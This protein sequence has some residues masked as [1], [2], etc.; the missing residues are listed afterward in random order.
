M[1][2]VTSQ[3]TTIIYTGSIIIMADPQVPCPKSCGVLRIKK[4]KLQQHLKG[5]CPNYTAAC[6]HCKESMVRRNI[7][8]HIEKTCLKHVMDCPNNCGAKMERL[9]LKKHMTETCPESTLSCPEGCGTSVSR[10]G[11]QQHLREDCPNYI[12]GCPQHCGAVGL[13]RKD[14]PQ[15]LTECCH[16]TVRCDACDSYILETWF[17]RHVNEE[18]PSVHVTCPNNC[19]VSPLQKDLQTH[20]EKSCLN[21]AVS[22]PNGCSAVLKR[23]NLKRHIQK[24]CCGAKRPSPNPKPS[25]SHGPPL[26][27]P[28]SPA[29]SPASP[30]VSAPS[31]A[32]SP[33]PGPA[34]TQT[35][36]STSNLV[37]SS[38]FTTC[39]T[40][41]DDILETLL[42]CHMNDDCPSVSVA[43][44][45]NCGVSPLR[46]HLQKHLEET[47]LNSTTPCP[48]GCSAKVKRRN[49]K[50]HLSKKCRRHTPNPSPSPSPTRSTDPNEHL[51]SNLTNT[52]SCDTCSG[53]MLET[54][55][56]YHM[57]VEC[58]N[59][60]VA[61]PKNCGVSLLRKDLEAHFE[62]SCLNSTVPC[63][64]GCRAMVKR[65]NLDKHLRKKCCAPS[66]T[67]IPQC[68]ILPT[69][70]TPKE[71][72]STILLRSSFMGYFGRRDYHHN[73]LPLIYRDYNPWQNVVRRKTR[74]HGHKQLRVKKA[75]PPDPSD[76]D[77][78]EDLEKYQKEISKLRQRFPVACLDFCIGDIAVKPRPIQKR[79]TASCPYNCKKTLQLKQIP[80]HLKTECPYS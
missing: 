17:Q 5:K 62:K 59:V 49:L 24:R 36:H 32:P 13:M 60:S 45:N 50:R 52:V 22:C 1:Y 46:K 72:Y 9:E 56:E 43:C 65:S 35:E 31:P 28:P 53:H 78:Y 15:H 57:N 4:S 47:C 61:C 69:Q 23:R 6:P 34:P 51:M 26:I 16:N 63:P 10:N 21:S 58:P 80:H 54:W 25:R 42:Q 3:V 79:V 12:V 68:N 66:P 73:R 2:I 70:T 40:C 11:L 8:K 20:V 64:D 74:S 14:I 41:G 19:G 29:S 75:V 76:C 71:L 48:N 39:D 44:P 67:P 33:A 30:P 77:P 55:L 18:C 7:K 27:P 37:S 38:S